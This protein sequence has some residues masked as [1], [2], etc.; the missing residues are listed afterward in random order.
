MSESLLTT[1]FHLPAQRADSVKRAHLTKRLNAGLGGKLTLV[2]APAGFGKSSLAADWLRNDL[3]A[4]YQGRVCWLSLDAADNH[5]VQFWQYLLAA[6]QRISPEI[7]KSF[8]AAYLKTSVPL[9]PVE[10]ILTSIINEIAQEGLPFLLSLDDFHEITSMEIHQ[11]VAFLVENLPPNLHILILS[12][13]DLPFSVSRYRV[14]GDLTEIRA[15][16]LR[17]TLSESVSFLNDLFG[18]SLSEAD[19]EALNAR[20]EGWIAGLQLAALSLRSVKDKSAFVQAFAGSHRFLT[21]YLIDEVLSRQ[22]QTIQKFLWR[23]SILERF[24]AEVCEKLIEEGDS[25]LILRQLEQANLFLIPL[26]DERRWFR[27]HHLFADFLRLRLFE[28]EEGI[29]T[30]LYQ[31]TI[32]WFEQAGLSR[33]ALQYAI[34]AGAYEQAAILI[35][36]LAPEILEKDNHMLLIEWASDLPCEI[37]EQRPF[38]CLNLGWAYVLSGNLEIAG[39]WLE[40]AEKLAERLPP[41]EAKNIYGPVAAHRAYIFF[42]QGNYTETFDVAQRALADLSTEEKALRARTLTCLGSAHNYAGR[43]SEAKKL[44]REA[45]QIA[46]ELES[47]PLAVFSYCSLGEVLRDECL[48]SEAR[49]TFQ[50]LIDFAEKLTGYQELPLSGYAILELGVIALEQYDL[51]LALEQ[52]QKGVRLCK[53]W[54]QGEA[55]ATGLLELAETRRL[56]GEFAEAEAVIREARQVT[57][58][59]SSWAFRLGECIAARLAL[60]RGEIKQAVEWA[61][62]AGLYHQPCDLGY[63]RYPECLPLI[64]LYLIEEEAQEALDLVEGLLQRDRALGRTWRVL[65]L[66]VL[67]AAAL[68]AL[69]EGDRALSSLAEALEIASPEKI[70][71]PFLDEGRTLLP[72]LRKLSV[73]PFRDHLLEILE[74]RAISSESAGVSQSLTEALNE[75]EIS[76]LRM[77]SAGLSN[78]EIGEELYLSVNTI[79]WYAAQIYLKLEVKNRSAAVARAR[80]LGIF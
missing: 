2:A 9:P 19:I 72:Y 35:E 16:D 53:E 13:E 66:L 56:R 31:R 32:L 30:E 37:L 51:N 80:E 79:R 23:T 47:L 78:R 18:L 64:R 75:R 73:S 61:E 48:L 59:I 24:N 62:G 67:Q 46:E 44:I 22:P 11:G 20:T 21:D 4:L 42:L 43:I 55:L 38:L 3:P 50:D 1:K 63:E 45:K 6:I 27:Y 41:A 65:D 5:P 28:N 49:N 71:R 58:R 60:S 12:R 54:Q 69:G 26:D 8:Q 34:K 7:G 14:S 33:E 70:V 76:I 52:I 74:D 10:T 25:R 15:A 36:R 17:F 29:V 68:H 40:A 77:M 39:K 57:A